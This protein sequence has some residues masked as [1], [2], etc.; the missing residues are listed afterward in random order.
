MEIGWAIDYDYC[1]RL[2]QCFILLFSAFRYGYKLGS[3]RDWGKS[4]CGYEFDVDC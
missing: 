4:Q 1:I 3:I 2:L